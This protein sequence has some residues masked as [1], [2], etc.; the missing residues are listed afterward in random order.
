VTTRARTIFL[1]SGAFAVPVVTTLAQRPEVD[2]LAAVTAPARPGSRGRLTATPVAEWAESRGLAL[3]Q[4]GRLRSP[5]AIDEIGGL[6]PELLVLADYGQIVPKALLDMP[7]F[8][9]LNLHPSLLP[10]HRGAAPIAATILEADGETGVS[11]M[12]MDAG[13]DTGPLLAQRR[14]ALQGDETAPDLEDRLANTAA[15]LLGESLGPWLRGELQPRPQPEEGATLTRPLRREDGRLDPQRSAAE[16]ERQV[17]AYQPW[18]G[19]F[20]DTPSGRII[21]WRARSANTIVETQAGVI[22]A[23]DEGLALATA[24]GLLELIE[25]QPAGGRRM[26]GAELLRGRP[27]L[28]GSTVSE[29]PPAGT[30]A[31]R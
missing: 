9:A 14:V 10:R 21:A 12:L 19:S 23:L 31:S 29:P 2:L 1:G 20:F 26:T 5:E 8:G 22:Q 27:A 30:A 13:V 24:D 11:L 7:R 28:A 25:V 15:T 6:K 4:P 17:R 3:L 18:P 16:L